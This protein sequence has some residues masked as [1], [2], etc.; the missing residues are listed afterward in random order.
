[1]HWS[2]HRPAITMF[3]TGETLTHGELNGRGAQFARAMQA[4]GVPEGGRVAMFLGN[5]IEYPVI[6]RGARFGGF[7][8]LP[9]NTHASCDELLDILHRYLSDVLVVSDRFAD[10]ASRLTPHLPAGTRLIMTGKAIDGWESF[11]AVLAPHSTEPIEQQAGRRPGELLLLSGG[12]TGSPKLVI[13]PH[14]DKFGD[15]PAGIMVGLPLRGDSV[16]LVASPLYHIMSL[17][18]LLT[19]LNTGGHVLLLDHWDS[20]DVLRAIEAHHVTL[21][22]LVPTMMVRLLGLPEHVRLKYDVSSIE[23]VLHSAAPCP[24]QVKERF[25]EWIPCIWEGYG[26]TEGFG[27][28]VISPEEARQRPGSVGRPVGGYRVTIRDKAGDE[29]PAGTE[30]IVWFIRTDGARMQYLGQPDETSASYNEHGEGTAW[31]LGYVDEAGYLYL[32]SRLKNMIISGGVNIFPG[33]I[34][35]VLQAHDAVSDVCVVGVPDDDLGEVPV[36]VVQLCRPELAST[37]LA[38]ELSALCREMLGGFMR[39]RRIVFDVIPRQATGKVNTDDV[40][41]LVR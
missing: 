22:P 39:P 23:A 15:S 38:D 14:A 33:R 13:R 28:C 26:M 6:L 8:R 20:E 21:L 1:M 37:E 3:Y 10:A 27:A 5:Q 30:G 24:S 25:M 18:W 31:D 32:V 41:V 4:G 16:A 17:A 29:V 34:E 36:A 11:D 40:L 2:H 9:L 19:V 35:D 7:D 12:S